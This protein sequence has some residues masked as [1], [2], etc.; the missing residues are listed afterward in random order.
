ML[1]LLKKL[2]ELRCMFL[3]RDHEVL[4][5]ADQVSPD[6]LQTVAGCFIGCATAIDNICKSNSY[7]LGEEERKEFEEFCKSKKEE[8]GEVEEKEEVTPKDL[9]AVAALAEEFSKSSDN[10]LRRQ[11]SVLDQVLLTFAVPEARE[12]EKRAYEAKI[13]EIKKNL[14]NKS[15]NSEQVKVSFKADEIAKVVD[16]NIKEYK[17]LEA[18]LKTR[19]CIDHP[20]H[21]LIRVTDDVYQCSLDKKTYDYKHGFTTLK[22]NKVPGGDIALQSQ[23]AYNA[24]VNVPMS[25]NSKK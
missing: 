18:P 5:L 6:M 19:S 8:L 9:E 2:E 22:G 20:G 13:S 17:P 1:E 3:N 15:E 4:D 14:N 7:K 24:Y 23:T 16:K 25:F 21:Q 11:A 10:L 12:E